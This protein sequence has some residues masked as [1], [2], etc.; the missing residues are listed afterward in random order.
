MQRTPRWLKRLT[1]QLVA[2]QAILPWMPTYGAMTLGASSCRTST[3]I[4]AKAGIDSRFEREE[5]SRCAEA[6]LH[7][8]PSRPLRLVVVPAC[9]GMT[10]DGIRTGI[11]PLPSGVG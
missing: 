4:P 7:H 10:V 11:V 9:A 3:V 8:A 2:C 6:A 1:G 5:Q